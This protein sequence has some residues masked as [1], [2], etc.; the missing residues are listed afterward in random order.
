[1]VFQNYLH[2]GLLSIRGKVMEYT[3]ATE[4][5]LIMKVLVAEKHLLQEK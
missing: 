2:T 1:M 4:F 3:Q 5:Y